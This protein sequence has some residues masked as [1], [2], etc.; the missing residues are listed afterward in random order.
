MKSKSLILP[1]G[2]LLVF[3]L[4]GG[5]ASGADIQAGKAKAGV[6]AGCHGPGGVSMN[7]DWPNLAGQKERYLAAQLKAFKEG[8]RNNPLMSPQAAMLSPADMENL[9]A[10]FASLPCAP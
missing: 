8:A 4:I 10:Y 9:A 6:C 3:C 2:L 1:A 5:P 7:P